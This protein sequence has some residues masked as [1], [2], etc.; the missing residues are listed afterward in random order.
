VK[1][2]IDTQK[3][4]WDK[5]W[6]RKIYTDPQISLNTP[7]TQKAYVCFKNF[8][9][10]KKDKLILEAGCGTGRFCCLF[11]K[12][13]PGSQIIG[14]DISSDSIKISQRLKKDLHVSNASF[15][16]ANLFKM[17]YPDNYFDVV[18]NEGVIEHYSMDSKPNYVDALREM[19][20]VTKKN[21]KVIIAVP[22]WFNFAHTFYKWTLTK[23]G[24]KYIYG[25]EKSFKHSE[26]TALLS[27][28]DLK[29]ISTSGFYPQ[30]GFYRLS[31][32]GFRRIFHILGKACDLIQPIVDYFFNKNFSKSFGIEIVIKGTKQ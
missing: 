11:A 22:N 13:F 19:V 9:D 26:I 21:G 15:M 4:I 17:P 2:S 5:N 30:H 27:Q 16:I 25:Y 10:A 24:K 28:F 31:G 6:E 14:M 20:R 8:L 7:F 32:K 18:F 29:E 3:G 12:D 23:L 1:I